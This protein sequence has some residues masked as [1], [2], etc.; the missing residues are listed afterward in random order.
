MGFGLGAL[1]AAMAPAIASFGVNTISANSQNAKAKRAATTAWNRQ[2]SWD[3]YKLNNAHQIEIQDLKNA[4]IN[5]AYTALTGGATSGTLSASPASVTGYGQIGTQAL[6]DMTNLASVFQRQQEIDSQI[7][8]NTAQAKEI[9][10]RTKTYSPKL[11]TD[12]AESE[13]RQR[14]NEAQTKET[15]ART[16]GQTLDNQIKSADATIAQEPWYIWKRRVDM[17][18]ESLDKVIAPGSKIAA[19]IGAIRGANSLKSASEALK[20]LGFKGGVRE[21]ITNLNKLDPTVVL[22]N[23]PY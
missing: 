20:T 13:T 5:P 18:A 4:G 8:L 22:K 11:E 15:I 9:R 17:I 14:Y 1:A 23:V 3:E 7:D 21:F 19:G 12:I 16:E 6:N 10:E 2:Q